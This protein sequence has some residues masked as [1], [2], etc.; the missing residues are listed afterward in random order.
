MHADD[1][2]K[3]THTCKAYKRTFESEATLQRHV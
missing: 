3:E 1:T 2:S